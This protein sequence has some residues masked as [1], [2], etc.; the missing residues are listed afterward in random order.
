MSTIASN[1]AVAGGACAVILGVEHAKMIASHGWKRDDVRR[2]LWANA[3]NTFGALSFNHRYG[4]VYNRSLPIWVKREPDSK[5]PLVA[6]AEDIHLFVAGGAAGR[7]SAFIP[8]WG[9]YAV[10]VLRAIDGVK[11]AGAVCVDGT[12]VL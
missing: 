12:C 2:Y 8:G 9:N 4:K 10:P 11:P 6:R 1:T 7:F 5:V 3:G